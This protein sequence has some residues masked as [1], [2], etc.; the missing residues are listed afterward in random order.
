MKLMRYLPAVT[1]ESTYF[2]GCHLEFSFS[3]CAEMCLMTAIKHIQTLR[4]PK[5]NEW[6]I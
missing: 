2:N 6:Q 4:S 5:Y 3:A 1:W